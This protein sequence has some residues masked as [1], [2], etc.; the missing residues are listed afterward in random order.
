MRSLP[1]AATRAL[2]RRLLRHK[3]RYYRKSKTLFNIIRYQ[4]RLRVKRR[5]VRRVR[6]Y[7]RSTA[8]VLRGAR[9]R[10]LHRRSVA[11]KQRVAYLQINQ[12][13][14][15]LLLSPA[16]V[17]VKQALRKLLFVRKEQRRR[18]RALRLIAGR[19]LTAAGQTVVAGA[20]ARTRRATAKLHRRLAGYS[21]AI[22]PHLPRSGADIR[23]K[24][25]KVTST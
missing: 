15:L 17:G 16:T 14:R 22:A 13:G 24:A 18:L 5:A 2:R 8:T 9:A 20:K 19:V 7:L 4:R 12:R 3:R 6:R 23:P 11:R 10:L 1:R 25:F 21:A